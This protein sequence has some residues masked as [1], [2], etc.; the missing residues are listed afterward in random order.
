MKVTLSLI[1]IHL[2]IFVYSIPAYA[3]ENSK[4]MYEKA[5][6]L[7]R[8]LRDLEQEI[9]LTHDEDRSDQDTEILTPPIIPMT[10][11]N[12]TLMPSDE[13]I[14]P[15]LPYNDNKKPTQAIQLLSY[16]NFETLKTSPRSI[17]STY[18]MTY[19]L[20]VFYYN[21]PPARIITITIRV[22]VSVPRNGRI[23]Q[24][25]E[26]ELVPED[27]ETTCIL[28]GDATSQGTRVYDCSGST[29]TEAT[30]ITNAKVNTN[31]DIILDGEAAK[32]EELALT[33]QA[34]IMGEDLITN[35][36]MIDISSKY[37]TLTDGRLTDISENTFSIVG[38][39]DNFN[40]KS[41]DI[42]DFNFVD[43]DDGTNKRIECKIGDP[44][45]KVD[46][47]KSK[48]TINCGP[49]SEYLNSNLDYTTGTYRGTPADTITLNIAEDSDRT[50]VLN[51]PNTKNKLPN[52]AIAGF[53]I[54]ASLL[55]FLAFIIFSFFK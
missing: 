30:V 22:Y 27:V 43:L 40:H 41:G 33:G 55:S 29:K 52:S 6:K 15:P 48:V 51:N 50:I 14:T 26:Y 16:G 4:T 45:E 36:E 46:D 31:E 47:T 11:P 20:L 10:T 3:D 25:E 2:L 17:I 1:M 54:I 37:L 34:I 23:L 44:I 9:I 39:I 28:K 42:F 35:S 49:Y 24:E 53:V 38:T 18:D 8:R 21:R 32:P 7:K 12:T 13:I 5:Q 19:T